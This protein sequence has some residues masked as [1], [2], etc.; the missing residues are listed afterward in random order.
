M[1]AIDKLRVVV[2][3]ES[4]SG[5]SERLGM[6]DLKEVL[7]FVDRRLDTE[8]RQFIRQAAIAYHALVEIQEEAGEELEN[9]YAWTRASRLWAAK[10]EDC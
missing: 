7:A 2:E 9:A 10:P 4:F 6:S 8:R 1:S 3:S 5:G